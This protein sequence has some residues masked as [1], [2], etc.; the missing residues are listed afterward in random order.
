MLQ[1]SHLWDYILV[2]MLSLKATDNKVAYQVL[3]QNLKIQETKKVYSLGI[4]LDMFY[5]QSTKEY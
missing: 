5:L 1:I 3:W 4:H 2:K